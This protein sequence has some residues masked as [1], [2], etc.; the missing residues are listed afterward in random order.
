VVGLSSVAALVASS[1]DISCEGGS[2]ENRPLVACEAA[3]GS[4]TLAAP[5][6]YGLAT[7]ALVTGGQSCLDTT[8][9][10]TKQPIVRLETNGG[11]GGFA[12][13]LT[14][15]LPASQGPATHTL[16]VTRPNPYVGV[17][18]Y[19]RYDTGTVSFRVVSGTVTVETSS[20]T[21]LRVTFDLELELLTTAERFS[22]TGGAATVSGCSIQQQRTC[23][24]GD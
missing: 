24:G 3:T 18:A 7:V 15:E 2:W 6:A 14:I 12:F 8:G 11:S 16:P 9:A 19:I 22:I 13:F 5:D 21:D 20:P 10:C 23:I 17:S 1:C 4:A